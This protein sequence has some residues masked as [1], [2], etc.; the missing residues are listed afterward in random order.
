[1]DKI[2]VEIHFPF[3]LTIMDNKPLLIAGVIV[4]LVASAFKRGYKLQQEQELTI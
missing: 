4:L 2:P 3:W 1:M